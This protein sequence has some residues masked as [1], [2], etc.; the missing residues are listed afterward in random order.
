MIPPMP[1][2]VTAT[3]H[4]STLVLYF[5]SAFL[6]LFDLNHHGRALRWA[7][8][9]V[10]A[11]FTFNSLIF[12]VDWGLKGGMPPIGLR[13]GFALLAW[14]LALLFILME[15]GYGVSSLGAFVVPVIFFSAAAASI[16]HPG[17]REVVREHWN[18]WLNLHVV[19]VFLGHGAFAL[20]ATLG[21]MYLIQE[22]HLKEKR[23]TTLF[24]RLG[25]VG[26][27]DTMLHRTMVLGFPLLTLGMLSGAVYSRI[28]HG[29]F[30]AWSPKELWSLAA[31]A[32]YAMLLYG[33]RAWGWHGRRAAFF[34]IAGF[35][36]YLL[37]YLGLKIASWLVS[38]GQ[39]V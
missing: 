22:K 15:W 26:E 36:A 11:A 13:E 6:Y 17:G 8:A 25:A 27:L 14:A 4:A 39:Y 7:R 32:I 24:F 34:A 31:W 18:L 38:S 23:F 33:H 35:V 30:W 28:A 20:A 12:V 2:A 19:L 21:V 9:L 5:V 1:V 3:F 10:I 29:V 37:A 16:F